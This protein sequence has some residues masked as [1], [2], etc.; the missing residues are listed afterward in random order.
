MRKS[1]LLVF[2]AIAVLAGCAKRAPIPKADVF[3]LEAE[4]AIAIAQSEIDE[5]EAVGADVTEP[6]DILQDARDLLAREDYP[7]AKREADR[8]ADIARKLKEEILAGQRARKDAEAAIQRAERLISQAKAL[9]GD[10]SD[11][12]GF[13]TRAKSEFEDE[14]Y[15][16]AI[17]FADRAAELAQD[18]INTLRGEKYVVGTWE[19]DRDCLWNIAKKRHIFND[20]WK[21]K[22]IY[23][24]N[25]D[26]IKDPNLIYPGQV[27]IIP[28]D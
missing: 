6:K 9:G 5:A 21:W 12:Q 7:G 19:A 23:R 27:L 2:C 24:V 28:K 20:P 13:L 10:V 4:R 16:R 26:K 14:S 3:R 18:I 8:A 25:K 1:S 15:S 11:A 22:R 17:E